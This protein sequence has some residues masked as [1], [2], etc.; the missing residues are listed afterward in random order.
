MQ[1]TGRPISSER[2]YQIGLIQRLASDR[3]E[4]MAQADEIADDILKGAP[5]AVK[6]VK[7]VVRVGRNVPIEYSAK[8]SEPIRDAVYLSEDRREGPKAFA[9]KR[10]PEWRNR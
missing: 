5:L 1:L 6:A 10:E 7:R 3:E 2:A 8:F 9:E 4:L